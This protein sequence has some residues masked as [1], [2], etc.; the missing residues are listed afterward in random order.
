MCVISELSISIRVEYKAD[1]ECIEPLQFHF[2]SIYTRTLYINIAFCVVVVG[3]VVELIVM[4]NR[5]YGNL[6][7]GHMFVC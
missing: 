7:F 5:M 4:L 6:F 1:S 2:I 3:Q